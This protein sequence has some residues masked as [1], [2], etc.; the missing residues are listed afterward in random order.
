[1]N[2]LLQLTRGDKDRSLASPCMSYE[3]TKGGN[4]FAVG[5]VSGEGDP[6]GLGPRL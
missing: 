4:M 2:Y 1:M 6:G 3:A 5:C